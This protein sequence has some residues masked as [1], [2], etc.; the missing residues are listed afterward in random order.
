MLKYLLMSKAGARSAERGTA[1]LCIMGDIV[2]TALTDFDKRLLN[3]LQGNLPVCSRPFARLGEMLDTTE[4]HVLRRLEDLKNEG[5][6][7]RIGIFFN[8]ERL[9]YQGT[10]IALEVKQEQLPA[11]AQAINRYAGATHNYEREGRYNL[12]FTLLT[13]SREMEQRILSEI[14]ALP[15]VQNLM[16]LKAH[17]RYKIN[18]QFKLD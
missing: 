18:V 9:G 1:G 11:V 15:G 4:A 3:L 5:Y 6:L 10:L 16:S 7:R 12:W 2:M 14:A 17:R 13:P 8:S